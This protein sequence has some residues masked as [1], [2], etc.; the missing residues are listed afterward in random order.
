MF[1][2]GIGQLMVEFNSTNTELASF[3]VSI[4]LLGFAVG[5]LV[6]SPAS[7][8]WG[9]SIIYNVSNVCFALCSVGC[10]LAPSLNFLIG[11]RFLSGCFGAAPLTI[12]GGTIAD[13]I[14]AEKRGVAMALFAMG[15]LMGPVIGP[16][17]GGFLSD[18]EGWRWVFWVLAICSG[19]VTITTFI[20][21]KETYA[22]AIL[23]AKARRLR[24]STGN[25][26]LRSKLTSSLP[27]KEVFTRALGRPF[28][29]LF[30]S[31]IVLIMSIHMAVVYGYLYLLFTTFPT[32]FE[33]QY[34]FSTA[35][36]GLAYLGI[37]VGS[38]VGLLILGMVS[39]RILVAKTRR[40]GEIKPEYRLP[41][42]AYGAPLIPVG[43]FWYGWTADYAVHWIVP[44][45]GT[46][47]VGVGLL[48]TFMPV[49]TYIVDAYQKYAASG[50]AATT[51]LRSIVGACLPLAGPKMYDALGLGWG[52][53]VLGFIALMFLP[54]PFIFERYGERLRKRYPV[55]FE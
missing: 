42:M 27:P 24:K 44:I 25:M 53:S 48:A 26:K 28:K 19:V 55:G 50:L 36:V 2:P 52:N 1:A 18:A 31:P 6:L 41:P 14:P 34:G 17:A 51:V 40:S 20:F 7:E 9:R 54:M 29:M 39:D 16:V 22:P 38:L 43:L 12:G 23:E 3:V 13:V 5:P 33:G 21:L 10:A 49:N 30:M 32:V 47:L 35:T 15:P 37:G 11:F 46:G 8:L 4:F 45:I